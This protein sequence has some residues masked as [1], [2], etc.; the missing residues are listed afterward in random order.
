[1]IATIRI[2]YRILKLR[3]LMWVLRRLM[4]RAERLSRPERQGRHVGAVQ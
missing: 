3:S 2:R 4:V 1:M